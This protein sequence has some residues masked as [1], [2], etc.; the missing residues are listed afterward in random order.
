MPTAGPQ[1]GDFAQMLDHIKKRSLFP[2]ETITLPVLHQDGVL[3]NGRQYAGSN[4]GAKIR[5][6]EKSLG[7][8]PR[9]VQLRNP[10]GGGYPLAYSVIYQKCVVALFEPGSFACF[11]LDG[12]TRDEQLERQLNS[13]K[14]TNQ[15]LIVGQLIGLS[16][17]QHYAFDQASRT[18]RP[19]REP[20]PF[21]EAPKLF[22]DDRYL[23]YAD[24]Q[25]E[26]G[27]NAYFF[28]KKKHTTRRIDATCAAAVW[29]E[30]GQYRLLASLSHMMSRMSCAAIP[31]V[32]ALP[33][34]SASRN[35]QQEWQYTFANSV[36]NPAVVPVFNY[37]SLLAFGG[38]RWQGQ[39]LYYINW[40]NSTFLATITRGIIT[41][42]DPLFNN[43]LYT[44]NP[45]TTSYG[46][47]LVLT[48]LDFYGLGGKREVA[49][50]VLQG[51]QL[52]K[53][54]WGEQPRD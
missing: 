20:V 5:L 11:R 38:F 30:Q 21:G 52:T 34:A 2:D 50:L 28:D 45:I 36:P 9:V 7:L 29:Q 39:T 49:A 23:V 33:L 46:P 12:L 1:Y 27:G 43:G 25:G 22:E 26:F 48:N 53:I 24:C 8:R 42:V 17:G 44:H 6:A 4:I 19:Y 18:W 10:F 37:H 3:V 47:E 32:E 40:R 54:A 51:R 16:G 15:W 41:V 14:F 35:P 31:N 13:R